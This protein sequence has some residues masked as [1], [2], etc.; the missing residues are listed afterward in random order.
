METSPGPMPSTKCE[1]FFCYIHCHC[2]LKILSYSANTSCGRP[3]MPH[4]I[5]S[6]MKDGSSLR[7]IDQISA[8]KPHRCYDFAHLLL[9]DNVLVRK[10]QNE[11]KDDK[12]GFVREVLGTWLSQ[13]DDTRVSVPCTWKDLAECIARSNLDGALAKAIR[14]K[15]CSGVLHL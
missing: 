2:G 6:T 3:D 1:I 15:F 10:H 7:I 14:D 13:D 4:L 9:K 12:D 8:S 5:C 11:C